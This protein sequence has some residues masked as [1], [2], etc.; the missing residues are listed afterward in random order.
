MATK[1]PGSPALT[2]A[3]ELWLLACA[4]LTLVPD[5]EHAPA[6]LTAAAAVALA[7]RTAVWWRRAALPPRRLLRF[8]AAAGPAGGGWRLRG[9]ETTGNL[10]SGWTK[11]RPR[12]GKGGNRFAA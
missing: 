12:Q 2:R 7:W 11:L 8:F 5:V 3:Q 6:W 9:G 1:R 10:I 4:V